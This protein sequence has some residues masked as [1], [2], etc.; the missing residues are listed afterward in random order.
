[1]ALHAGN[2]RWKTRACGNQAR[3]NVQ[4]S[5]TQVALAILPAAGVRVPRPFH[6]FHPPTLH[7]RRQCHIITDYDK[8]N[9]SGW[10]ARR[11]RDVR[12]YAAWANAARVFR[13]RLVFRRWG[14]LI[15]CD[16]DQ[17]SLLELVWL[18]RY[19]YSSLYDDADRRLRLFGGS[20]GCCSEGE[21]L[22]PREGRG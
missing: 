16:R 1:M 22:G 11:N 19:V 20:G 6:P 15:G 8:A 18:P 5:T 21:E 2:E 12:C 4:R 13:L 14:R 9:L 17:H 3:S 7:S 10:V